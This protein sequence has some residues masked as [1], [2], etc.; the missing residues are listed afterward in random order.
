LSE[1]ASILLKSGRILTAGSSSLCGVN[2][3]PEKTYLI[4]GK[5]VAGKARVSLCN[6]ITPWNQLTV[7]QKKGFR[8]LYRQNC[9][10]EIMSCPWWKQCPKEEKPTNGCQWEGN[11]T[12][13]QAKHGICM[14]SP[15]GGCIWSTDRKFNEC[16][17]MQRRLRDEKLRREP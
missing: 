4:T 1:K 16:T 10:C 12:D 7:R 2:L 13:C 8:L 5:V 11:V 14:R 6:Y 3:T 9:Q 17:K 15:H